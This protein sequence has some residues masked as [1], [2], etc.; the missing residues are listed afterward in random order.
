[1][2][3]HSNR[4]FQEFSGIVKIIAALFLITFLF[5]E[6]EIITELYFVLSYAEGYYRSTFLQG[7]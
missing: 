4:F 5:L 1:M 7:E 2:M 6:L 3:D